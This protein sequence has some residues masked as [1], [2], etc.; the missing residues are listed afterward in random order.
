M[1]IKE[2]IAFACIS[3]LLLLT[4]QGIAANE[5]VEKISLRAPAYNPSTPP[6]TFEDLFFPHWFENGTYTFSVPE[7]MHHFKLAETFEWDPSYQYGYEHGK[8][9]ICNITDNLGHQYAG[10]NNTAYGVPV[11]G[12]GRCNN[13]IYGSQITIKVRGKIMIQF[14]IW[15]SWFENIIEGGK[16]NVTF[17]GSKIA[18]YMD[19]Y[20][21]TNVNT[22][23]F[24]ASQPVYAY[25]FDASGNL[26]DHTDKAVKSGSVTEPYDATP[27]LTFVKPADE[28]GNVTVQF[29]MSYEQKKV[30]YTGVGILAGIFLLIAVVAYFYAKRSV[31][32]ERGRKR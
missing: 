13:P 24:K 21:P 14:G 1:H 23:Y 4:V 32:G 26:I 29:W 27:F 25:L 11:G 5:T 10:I 15:G 9:G 22:F 28:S 20:N 31:Y 2:I 17:P 6:K 8:I 7:Y 19:Y 3:V 30:D 12:P 16:Y 18:L